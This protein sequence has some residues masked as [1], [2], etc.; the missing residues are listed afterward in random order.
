M[1]RKILVAIDG[2]D[3][4]D[5]ALDFAVDLAQKYS[6]KILLLTVVPPVFLPIPSMN[7]MKSQ[8]IADASAELENSFRTVLSKAEEKVKRLSNMQL[9]TR[10]E[11][12][13]PDEV[14]VET[15]KMGNFDVIVIGSRGMS[16]RDYALGS[17][18]SRVAE[19]ATC[20]VLIVK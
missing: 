14:I 20:P 8:A 15:A 17:V 3:H 11:H 6:A 10:L 9:F 5:N 12:G 7:I 16:R 1:I 19:N 18:S 4:A 2:S 13:H